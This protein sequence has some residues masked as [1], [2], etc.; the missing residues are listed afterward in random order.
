MSRSDLPDWDIFADIAM[1]AYRIDQNDTRF[2]PELNDA[3]RLL[4][5][6][7]SHGNAIAAYM[8]F[9]GE[10]P[11]SRTT[12]DTGE[13]LAELA[14]TIVNGLVAIQHLTRDDRVTRAVLQ[15]KVSA[16]LENRPM[17]DTGPRP[18]ITSESPT[19]PFPYN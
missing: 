4:R 5:I 14:A 12:Y 16:T 18:H 13:I 17:I 7:E 1:I 11:S 3:I 6:A 8:T 19:E 2:H 9:I 10:N 15:S